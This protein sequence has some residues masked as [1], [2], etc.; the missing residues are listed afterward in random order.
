MSLKFLCKIRS[1]HGTDIESTELLLNFIKFTYHNNY[2]LTA[3]FF[4]G[5]PIFTEYGSVDLFRNEFGS[6]IDPFA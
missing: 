4:A 3:I 1:I 2:T 6:N 5:T